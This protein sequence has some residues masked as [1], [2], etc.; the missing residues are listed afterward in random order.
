MDFQVWSPDDLKWPVPLPPPPTKVGPIDG[1]V[2][3]AE[4][5]ESSVRHL[6]FVRIDGRYFLI[7]RCPHGQR[8]NQS[9]L[10]NISKLPITE[11]AAKA[12]FYGL[13]HHKRGSEMSCEDISR[14]N[15]DKLWYKET[16]TVSNNDCIK[17]IHLTGSNYYTNYQKLLGWNTYRNE[18]TPQLW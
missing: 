14:Y 9:S 6:V 12:S 3:H 13:Q 17:D 16:K 2:G 4:L 5:S 10:I 8:N 1:G 18:G 11:C 15:C 7:V